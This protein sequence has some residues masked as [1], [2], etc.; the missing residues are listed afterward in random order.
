MQRGPCRFAEAVSPH[1]HGPSG[2]SGQRHTMR[3][4]VHWR[5]GTQGGRSSRRS[6]GT[7]KLWLSCEQCVQ[8]TRR[9][10]EVSGKSGTRRT[11]SIRASRRPRRRTQM[12][13][14]RAGQAP[15]HISRHEVHNHVAAVRSLPVRSPVAPPGHRQPST[16]R[17]STVAS[18]AASTWPTAPP[19]RWR[20]V[21]EGRKLPRCSRSRRS[22]G[23]D[24]SLVELHWPTH[25][26]IGYAPL[27]VAFVLLYGH[28][29]IRPLGGSR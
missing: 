23:Q 16:N 14:P 7:E 3:L 18:Q 12:A 11:M 5:W 2:I 15:R 4:S 26:L 20:S 6:A 10:S 8:A 25:H 27:T 24:S 28:E 9:G 22:Q 13:D 29:H 21:V 1:R 19:T 17:A